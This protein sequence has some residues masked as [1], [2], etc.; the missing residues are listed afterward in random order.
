VAPGQ[1]VQYVMQAPVQQGVVYA[2]SPQPVAYASAQ[3]V[4]YTYMAPPAGQVVLQDGQQVYAEGME[5][6]QVVLQ[7]GQQVLQGGQVVL[8]EG[9]QVLQDG[10]VVLQEG[11]QVLQGGQLVYA[12]P[13]GQQVFLQEGQ[14]VVQQDMQFVGAPMVAAGP[15]RV[16]ISPEL[17][18]KL[19]A[20]GQMTPEEMA[21]L[22]GQPAPGQV[23]AGQPALV[24][25]PT[26]GGSVAVQQ[27]PASPMKQP[28]PGSAGAA[29]AAPGSAKASGK[30]EKK[31][32]SGSKKSLKASKKK[33]NKGCC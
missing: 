20:G 31:D 29:G 7:E 18:A 14:Q 8:Q 5:G 19:A 16:N 10:Q 32:K 30:K 17:F 13:E 28:T 3:P 27:Q 11:Q 26:P 33:K 1:Q 22:S 21:Q 4:Q 15:A 23:E 2:Q 25:Q 12:A 6:Q 24:Q 9:Q